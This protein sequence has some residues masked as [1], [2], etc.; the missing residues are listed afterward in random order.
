MDILMK[1]TIDFEISGIQTINKSKIK[2]TI[3]GLYQKKITYYEK[4]PYETKVPLEHDWFIDKVYGLAPP[5]FIGV[6]VRFKGN[7]R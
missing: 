3:I 1:M 7:I 2:S 4:K 6:N 5:Y